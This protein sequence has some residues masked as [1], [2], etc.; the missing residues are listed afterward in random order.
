MRLKPDQFTSYLTESVG[1]SSYRL[2]THTGTT[3]GEAGDRGH[4]RAGD[5]PAPVQLNVIET[6]GEWAHHVT[7]TPSQV[8]SGRCTCSTKVLPR[9]S[10]V[11]RMG[12]VMVRRPTGELQ[13]AVSVDAAVG[14]CGGL[15]DEDGG[16]GRA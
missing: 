9:G 1:F 5:T 13:P 6:G 12:C 14:A 3:T 2:L 7:L 15:A 16:G 10:E 8:S 4:L 11:T